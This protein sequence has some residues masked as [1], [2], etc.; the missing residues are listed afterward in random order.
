VAVCPSVRPSVC[1]FITSGNFSAI[2]SNVQL[3]TCGCVSDCIVMLRRHSRRHCN[4]AAASV[5]LVKYS[6][7]TWHWLVSDRL[8]ADSGCRVESIK[9][10]TKRDRESDRERGG[11]TMRVGPLQH[12]HS[13]SHTDTP[14][15]L[16]NCNDAKFCHYDDN[17]L[18]YASHSVNEYVNFQWNQ[19][20]SSTIRVSVAY[21]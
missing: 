8:T 12:S 6:L 20:K 7:P 9:M 11:D 4:C 17:V 18:C 13:P 19:I 14:S 10:Q 5:I 21:R 16:A 1:L 15:A 2:V 3:Q